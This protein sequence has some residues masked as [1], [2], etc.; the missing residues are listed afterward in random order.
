MRRNSNHFAIKIVLVCC[1]ICAF[2]CFLA[3]IA[4]PHIEIEGGESRSRF[5]SVTGDDDQPQPEDNS[6]VFIL[7]YARYDMY[8]LI[9]LECITHATQD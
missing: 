3:L 6:R 8:V 4:T 1:L 2:V 5:L 9:R 7:A